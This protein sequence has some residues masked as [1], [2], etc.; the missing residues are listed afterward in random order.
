VSENDLW[1]E[2]LR[3]RKGNQKEGTGKERKEGQEVAAEGG[4]PPL[5]LSMYRILPAI[6]F[7]DTL[8]WFVSP[9]VTEIVP[10]YQRLDAPRR[11]GLFPLHR[12][13]ANDQNR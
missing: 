13:Y 4:L 12:G 1:S 7:D 6:A 3:S 8:G 2:R 10:D 9:V 5:F 11:S